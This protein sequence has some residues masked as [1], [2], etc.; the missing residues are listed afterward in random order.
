M[1]PSDREPTPQF[2]HPV[3][4]IL[5]MCVV[6]ILA[7]FGAFLA[8]PKVLPIFEASPILNGI[9]GTVFFVGVFACFWQVM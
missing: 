7:G 8:L 6:L 1:A 5:T 2:S 4:Q 3:R 9:I